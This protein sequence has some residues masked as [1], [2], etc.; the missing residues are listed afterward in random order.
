MTIRARALY[1][2]YF[3]LHEPLVQTQVLPYLRELVAGGV[4]MS[5]L[6]F[7]PDLKTR[8]TSDSIA[9]WRQRLREAGIEW[10]ML[11]YHKHPSLPAT[12][13]DILAGA[14]R[15]AA[16]SIANPREHDRQADQ[17]TAVLQQPDPGHAMNANFD[18]GLFEPRDHANAARVFVG[19]GIPHQVAHRS[20]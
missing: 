12:M 9:A 8:W 10:H 11:P 18:H 1:L 15:A 14:W 19:E 6:T 4:G 20:R 5:L 17:R 3:S 16:Q 13:Y 7:E 2:C